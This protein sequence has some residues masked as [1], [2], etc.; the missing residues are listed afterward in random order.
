MFSLTIKRVE[1]FAVSDD[2]QRVVVVELVV[3]LVRVGVVVPRLGGAGAVVRRVLLLTG[4]V[5]VAALRTGWRGDWQTMQWV[6]WTKKT[7]LAFERSLSLTSPCLEECGG[8][9]Q[10]CASCR[11]WSCASPPPPTARSVDRKDHRPTASFTATA[12]AS[13]GGTNCRGVSSELRGNKVK[14]LPFDSQ[15]FAFKDETFPFDANPRRPLLFHHT[16]FL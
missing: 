15:R 7:P 10:R 2:G 11:P 6:N 13:R 12:S 9:C 16:W 8:G 1:R 4:V 14:T 5:C 3:K